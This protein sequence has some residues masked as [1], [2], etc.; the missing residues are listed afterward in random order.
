MR[1]TI[2]DV[3]KKY[4]FFYIFLNSRN[5]TMS[6]GYVQSILVYNIRAYQNIPCL[7]AVGKSKKRNQKTPP[8]K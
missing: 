8:S 4:H 1:A 7:S 2:L 5:A 3:I 6:S